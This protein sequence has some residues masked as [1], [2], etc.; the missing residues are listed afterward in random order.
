MQFLWDY[1]SFSCKIRIFVHKNISIM[2]HLKYIFIILAILALLL[3]GASEYFLRYALQPTLKSVPQREWI[4]SVMKRHALRDTFI[5]SRETGDSIHAWYLRADSV[6]DKVAVLVHGYTDNALWMGD[7]ASIYDR[8]L[9]YNILLPD[10]HY[11]GQSKGNYVQMGWKDR[12]DLLQWCALADSLFGG[13]TCQVLHG[14]SMGAAT[15]MSVSGEALPDYIRCFV[16][17]CGYT[18]VWEEFKNSMDDQFS[19]PPFPLLHTTSWLCKLRNGWSFS[20]ASPLSQVAKADRPMLF[21]H[22]GND[23]FVNTEM[24]YRLYAAKHGVKQLWI[25]PGAKHARSYY[26]H[27]S[28]YAARVCAFVEKYNSLK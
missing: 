28:E 19:L 27:P 12:L 4:D 22:G 26:D 7:I 21:I 1:A 5:V 13:N 3:I 23:S 15:I 14:V 16:E 25:A 10:L 18:S 11:H 2:K 6:T 20:E 17:D 24:V 8:Q 9:H